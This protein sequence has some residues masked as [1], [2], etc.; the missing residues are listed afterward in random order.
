MAAVHKDY[1][2][3]VLI[4]LQ[5]MFRYAW[6]ARELIHRYLFAG[7][8]CCISLSASGLQWH[9]SL[10]YVWFQYFYLYSQLRLLFCSSSC[11]LRGVLWARE[12][13]KPF[14]L[15]LKY[16][17]HP[18]PMILCAELSGTH[19]GHTGRAH[20]NLIAEAL[21]LPS[22]GP[23]V[24]FF[25]VFSFSL[26]LKVRKEVPWNEQQ[27]RED[28]SLQTNIT[29]SHSQARNWLHAVIQTVSQKRDSVLETPSKK[30]CSEG[31]S[32]AF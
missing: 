21:L 19:G 23:Q 22:K 30:P 16:T 3:H 24:S 32:C 13:R 12:E 1:K 14:L 6:K 8:G 31:P 7:Q 11:M 28:S 29:C 4:N 2:Q 9:V 17:C 18:L 15:H 20:Y 10:L 5:I 26:L 27:N 25:K